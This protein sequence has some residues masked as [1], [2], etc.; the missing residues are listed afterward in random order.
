MKHYY[1]ADKD[2]Q[3]GPFSFDE[4]KT[5]RLKKKTLVWTDG[6]SEWTFAEN[7]P[8]LHDILISEPPPLP[9]KAKENL[10]I[11]NSVKI[12]LVSTNSPSASDNH[13]TKETEA[14]VVGILLILFPVILKLFGTFT[15]ESEES[16]NQAK[17][18]FA[19]VSLVLRILVTI[20][21]VAIAKR[22]NRNQSGWGWF[23]FFLPSIALII[24]G[25][26]KKMTLK[27][28]L[29]NSLSL[30]EQSNILNAKALSLI[31][32]GRIN[33]ALSI[34]QKIIEI[35]PSFANIGNDIK[36]LQNKIAASKIRKNNV[37]QKSLAGGQLMEFERSIYEYKM[38]GC[39]VKIDGLVPNDCVVRLRDEDYRYEIKS[40]V[41]AKQFFIDI[42]KQPDGTILEIDIDEV[43][44]I[45][46]KTKTGS[47]AWI[48]NHPAPDGIYK[49]GLFRKVNIK[50]GVIE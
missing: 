39:K 2:Q 31:S 15:F 46:K 49:T 7:I 23:A 22:Q 48:N 38:T 40:G 29:D 21:V 26:L 32:D 17:A 47:R 20:W 42:F 28:E 24:I 12:K 3:L 13:Y 16:F 8:E 50:N 6:L 33:E 5:K 19:L 14:T 45:G 44:V 10:S 35:N 41:I 27:I 18:I 25:V 11:D 36:N 30:E 34:L 4:L 37:I 1:Y 43:V 9:A